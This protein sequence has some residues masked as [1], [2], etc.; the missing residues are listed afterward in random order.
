MSTSTQSPR[1]SP[2]H[3]SDTVNP[4]SCS[5]LTAN[6]F[7][8]AWDPGGASLSEQDLPHELPGQAGTTQAAA[9]K[10]PPTPHTPKHP[11]PTAPRAPGLVVICVILYLR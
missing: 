1:V 7:R 4:V 3:G 5:E 10:L 8:Q 11:I 9:R 2:H 6:A